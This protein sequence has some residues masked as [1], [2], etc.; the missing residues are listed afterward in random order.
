MRLLEML[1]G[2]KPRAVTDERL[3][4]LE[5]RADATLDRAQR[6]LQEHE[7]IDRIARATRNTAAALRTE[8]RR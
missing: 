4:V 7:R 1:F 6:A 2:R 5:A 3:D 8:R